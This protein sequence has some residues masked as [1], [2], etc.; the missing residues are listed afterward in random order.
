MRRNRST[1]Y[2]LQVAV[3]GICLRT[4]D[5]SA[6]CYR[7]NR[8]AGGLSH[9]QCI[10]VIMAD[11][12]APKL[13][14]A[15]MADAVNAAADELCSKL[16][17]NPAHGAASCRQDGRMLPPNDAIGCTTDEPQEWVFDH[18]HAIVDGVACDHRHPSWQDARLSHGQPVE[19]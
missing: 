4:V 1:R 5:P 9:V 6:D 11:G 19:G 8:A 17:E 15:E 12:D 18:F 13:S 10:A 3:C 16:C 7:A 14:A 2:A